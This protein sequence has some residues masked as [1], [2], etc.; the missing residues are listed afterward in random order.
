MRLTNQ[1]PDQLQ[2]VFGGEFV[3]ERHLDEAH[4]HLPPEHSRDIGVAAVWLVFMAV[5]VVS[6]AVK[7][8]GIVIDVLMA[9]LH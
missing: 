2:T 7:G 1:S 5:A 3:E 8:F 6:V 9:S 4:R